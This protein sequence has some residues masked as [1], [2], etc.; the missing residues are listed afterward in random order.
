VDFSTLTEGFDSLCHLQSRIRF[1]DTADTIRSITSGELRGRA[2]GLL[3]HFQGRG[4]RQG[5]ELIL[6]TP[7]NLAFI[8][9]FWACQFGGIVPVPIAPGVSDDQRS[10][11]FR[12]Y[13]Q[14]KRPFLYTDH[15]TGARIR[16]LADRMDIDDT[17]RQ[18]KA[19]TVLTENVGDLSQPAA[20]LRPKPDDIAFIQFSSGSTR[21]PKGVVLTHRNLAVNIRDI[22][23]ATGLSDQ[24][25]SLSWMPLTHDMG[26]IG[27]HLAMLMRGLT[28]TIMATEV[29]IRRPTSWLQTACRDKVTLLCSPNFGYRLFLKAFG[30]W[31]IEDLDLSRIRLIFNGAEPISATVCE[32]F[33]DALAPHGLKRS[34]M[35]PVYGLAEAGL[36]VSFST[37]HQ[38]YATMRVQR[39]SLGPGRTVVESTADDAVEIVDVGKPVAHCDVRI[40][41]ARGTVLSPGQV[42]SIEISGPNVTGGYYGEHSPEPGDGHHWLDTGDVGFFKDDSLYIS[43]RLKDILFVNGQNHYAHDLENIV[44]RID[45]ID[46]GKVAVCAVD[47][48]DGKSEAIA[49]FVLHFGNP[50]AFASVATRVRKMIGEYAGVEVDLVIPVAEIPKTT[51]GKIMRFALRQA[52]DTGEFSAV[53]SGLP[54]D[55]PAASAQSAGRSD[56]EE[57]LLEICAG[58]LG[59]VNLQRH[60]NFFEI[61]MNSLKLIEIHELIDRHYPSQLEV[62]DIFDHPTLARL[63]AFLQARQQEG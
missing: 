38:G 17:Y 63:A 23:Q 47:D 1:V 50:E 18:L 27:F 29:F 61:G 14:L 44:C 26:L 25:S 8:D 7:N 55:E 21:D 33:L 3:H 15:Q 9:A 19:N 51:S 59:D 35:V 60:D 31:R 16:A 57:T 12:V 46:A 5:D 28:H 49:V 45:G 43:G 41:D 62:S 6:C 39:D 10:K 48:G 13:R 4:I 22:H 54:A 40:T 2:L 53:V 58:S 20:P 30:R 52:F 37:P 32:E 34:A 42:G 24:D 11:L 36:A 56:L